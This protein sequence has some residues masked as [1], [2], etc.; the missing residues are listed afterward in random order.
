MTASLPRHY[1]V[2]LL[3]KEEYL[4]LVSYKIAK[5]RAL[6]E[7]CARS[8]SHDFAGKHKLRNYQFVPEP[9][10]CELRY[11]PIELR[12]IHTEPKTPAR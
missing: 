2:R 7:E 1:L 9:L 6:F 5:N 10:H 4:R 3:T 12:L 11:A 8:A